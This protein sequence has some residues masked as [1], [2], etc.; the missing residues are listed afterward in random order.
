VVI[1]NKNKEF[2][3][4]LKRYKKKRL[5]VIDLV[6]MGFEKLPKEAMY[7]GICW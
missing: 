4:Y 1:G 6:N 3:E 2:L 7:E 5:H